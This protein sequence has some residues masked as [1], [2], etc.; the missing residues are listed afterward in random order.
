MSE[1]NLTAMFSKTL[2]LLSVLTIIT[3][4]IITINAQGGPTTFAGSGGGAIPDSP[5]T[6]SDCGTAG[7]PLDIKFNVAALPGNVSNVRIDLN[8]AHTWVAD[9]TATLIAP[10]GQSHILF[11]RTGATSP[12]ACGDNTNLSGVYEFSDAANNTNWW[13]AAANLGD[14]DIIPVGS[15]RTTAAG[16]QSSASN[17]P[18]T[19]LNAAFNGASA[20]GMWTLRI[21][22]SGVGDTGSVT[23]A[24]LT[25]TTVEA[26]PFVGSKRKLDFF[27]NML[28]DFAI[29]TFPSGGNSNVRWRIL[30]NDNPSTAAGARIIDAPWGNSATDI[31][32]NPGDYTGNGITDFNVYRSQSGSPANTY[33]I[34]PNN[35]NQQPSGN[36]VYVRWGLSQT[37][38]IGR[39]GDYDG[40]GKL[41]PT[42]IRD[43][44]PGAGN[45]GDN[46]V[47]YVLRSSDN[48]FMAFNYGLDTDIPL[49][50]A[51]Y[52]GDGTDDPTIIRIAGSG[53]VRW[54][55]GTSSGTVL[56]YTDWGD[57]AQDF[58]V[59]G[60]D[61]DGDGRADF[62]VW[63]GF[64][65][66]TNGRWYLR[67][68][69]G[70][71]SQVPFG[72]PGTS[73][74]RDTAL[75][76]GDY[77]GDGRDDIAVYR[78]SNTTFY[79]LKSG[80]GV[81]IQQWGVPGNTN[82]PLASYGIF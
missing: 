56:S 82:I 67:T 64:G 17:S 61:Y 80:G 5:G 41:D 46:L 33:H 18:V 29:L 66:G 32:P 35:P 65:S 27:G 14:A 75:R 51:D 31:V 40:D 52:N 23:A 9:V 62:M 12:T 2:T 60:G 44:N 6:P 71:T 73:T 48:T 77:D 16:P 4:S 69:T 63:R 68:A 28:T 24:N 72:I 74:T 45:D 47:W 25:L 22:D 11:G 34:L 8:I 13:M 3:V 76:G 81:T 59:P 1:M 78:P 39:E 43:P 20:N 7:A 15:Y 54:I 38:I 50:G 30:R 58:A 36:P 21:T 79:V 53:Q 49:P 26:P 10:N 70:N 37:D 55:V 57:F 42:A 19:S